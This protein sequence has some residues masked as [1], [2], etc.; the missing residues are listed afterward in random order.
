MKSKLII[1]GL[2]L[3]F[4]VQLYVPSSMMLERSEVLQEGELLK[5]RTAVVDPYDPFKGKYITLRFEENRCIDT[6]NDWL[7]DE[8]VYVSYK[9]DSLGFDVIDEVSKA[10]PTSTQRYVK[11]KV[12]YI[13]GD[14]YVTI[15]Y[16]FD[17]YYMNEYKAYDAELT[18]RDA[19]R[20]DTLQTYAVVK[21][22]N[23]LPVL[24]NVMID[25]QPIESYIK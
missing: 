16:D 24:E 14:E 1:I 23:G 6:V 7:R 2:V 21:V 9:L 25:D 15:D 8:T 19:N 3:L 17:R 4:V 20:A 22:K 11:A 13:Y 18:Y 10:I 12:G 5:L